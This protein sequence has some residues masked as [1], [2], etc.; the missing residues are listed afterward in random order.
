MS[1][2]KS[3]LSIILII[4]FSYPLGMSALVIDG[5]P[6][7][8]SPAT[9]EFP[10]PEEI[11]ELT[12]EKL[13]KTLENYRFN[14]TALIAVKGKIIFEEARGIA[15]FSNRTPIKIESS[16]QLASASKPFTA[17]SIMLLKERS[18]LDYDDKV[19]NYIP[20]FPYPEISIRHLLNHTSGL[21]NY[22]Y[23]VDNYWVNDSSITNQK[24]LNLIISHNLPLNNIPGRRFEYSNTGYA[25]LA[26]VIEKI[27]HQYFGDFLQTEIFDKL[28]MTHSYVYNRVD[29]EQ[30]SNQVLGY[31]S[32]WRRR[33]QYFH[34]ANNEILGDKSIYSTVHDI[35][36]FTEA[37]NNYELVDKKT[38]E[39]AYSK[40][41]LRN[42]RS[43]NYG[44]GWRLRK[45]GKHSYIFHNGAWHGFTSTITLEPENDITLILLNN[46]NAPIATI[47]RDILNILHS[48]MDPYL[49]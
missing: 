41:I 35:Y 47:K 26:L 5:K 14:G 38:L 34:D 44:F 3:L 28:G 19:K 37:L 27:T 4:L 6:L 39:E 21:Q 40:A 9:N 12:N 43:I 33:R 49:K 10:V 42:S 20:D 24:M 23:L 13:H 8:K 7:L 18:L 30:D 22:M 2:Y 15:N 1:I 29:I 46:T 17:L 32:Q 31:N 48:Q 11:V 25:V 16:F 36:K 45:D